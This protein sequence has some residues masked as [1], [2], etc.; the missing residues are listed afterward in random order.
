MNLLQCLII[1]EL[2]SDNLYTVYCCWLCFNFLHIFSSEVVVDPDVTT[3]MHWYVT[4]CVLLIHV[5][6]KL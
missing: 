4:V 5:R 1:A 6:V 2:Y 3:L